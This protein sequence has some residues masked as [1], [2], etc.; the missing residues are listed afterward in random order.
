MAVDQVNLL[1]LA[2]QALS[3]RAL[4]AITACMSFGLFCW[5]MTYA[6]WLRL[7]I[8]GTFAVLVFLPVLVKGAYRGKDE[9]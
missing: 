1:R 4:T 2:L 8:A 7:A 5:A 6:G 3:D 9:S